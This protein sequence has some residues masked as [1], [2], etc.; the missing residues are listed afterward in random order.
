M[1]FV[2]GSVY[3]VNYIYRLEYV[4][5]ALHPRDESYLIVVDKLFDVLLQSACQYFIEDF[6]IYVHHGYWLEVFFFRGVS[7]RFWYQDDVGLIK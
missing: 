1:I 4:E 3:V 2:F 5:P 7:A 6:C